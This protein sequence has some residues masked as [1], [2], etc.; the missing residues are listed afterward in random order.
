MS[1]LECLKYKSAPELKQITKASYEAVV[2]EIKE[3]QAVQSDGFF[4]VSSEL[5]AATRVAEVMKDRLD[6]RARALVIHADVVKRAEQRIADAFARN[7]NAP[8]EKVISAV[9]D[10][11]TFADEANA[12]KYGFMGDSANSRIAY[13][14]DEFGRQAVDAIAL[15]D[16]YRVGEG[17]T[18]AF[19]REVVHE[20]YF[21][22]TGKGKASA[23]ADVRLAA[24]N[25]RE[26]ANAG[27]KIFKEKGGNITLRDHYFIGLRP[28]T[29]KLID[30]GVNE[31]VSDM[32]KWGNHQVLMDAGVP[33]KSLAKFYQ[34]A[35]ISKITGGRVSMPDYMPKGL[36]SVVNSRNHER[37]L[38]IEAPKDWIKFH[39][40]YGDFDLGASVINYTHSIG[41]DI[42]ILETYGPKPE[43]LMRT[44]LRQAYEIDPVGARKVESR[45]RNQFM[46]VTGQWDRDTDPVIARAMANYRAA[47]AAGMLGMTVIDA[48]VGDTFGLNFIPKLIR[49][50]PVL[51]TLQRDLAHTFK[52][53]FQQD[54]EMWARLGWSMEAFA[55]ATNAAMRSQGATGASPMVDKVARFVLDKTGLTRKTWATKGANFVSTAEYLAD[56][57]NLDA[58][59][60]FKQWLQTKGITKEDLA[61]IQAHGIEE[62]EGYGFKVVSVSKLT[63]SGNVELA[64]RVHAALAQTAELASP[65]SSAKWSARFAGLE[66]SGAAGAVLGGSMKTFTGYLASYWENHYRASFNMPGLTPKLAM[67]VQAIVV[68]PMFYTMAGMIRDMLRGKEPSLNE[69]TLRSAFARSNVIPIIGDFLF[70]GGQ[71]YTGSLTDRL[72]GTALSMV[73]DGARAL[74]KAAQGEFGKAGLEVYHSLKSLVPMQ[75]GW[76]TNIILQRGVFDFIQNMIDPDAQS[77]FRRQITKAR[78]DGNPY[79]IAPGTLTR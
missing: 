23:N 74:T 67:A 52:T 70:T 47:S 54:K 44:L 48:A 34:Q 38:H 18:K 45:V 50:L 3:L 32:M 53:G 71:H 12:Y 28:D 4:D 30:A 16:K 37:L 9:L 36:R 8:K 66:R 26:L 35:Y 56:M 46:Y 2:K 75:N 72:S 49:G 19:E 55:D 17:G 59:P 39:E 27:G 13:W 25:I 15:I 6:T 69:A 76:Y 63:E 40:K 29:K 24:Q 77:K 60:K 58:H 33:P 14:R 78:K 73:N 68:L 1:V 61:Y 31:F 43:A 62:V 79:F 5:K 65:T 10:S 57:A 64:G 51:R 20:M 42:G 11:F 21:Q 41:K 22:A 7:P